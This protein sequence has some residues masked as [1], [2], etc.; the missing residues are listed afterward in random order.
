MSATNFKAVKIFMSPYTLK[1]DFPNL[2]CINQRSLSACL[3]TDKFSSFAA[4]SNLFTLLPDK[5]TDLISVYNDAIAK[6]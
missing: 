2:N 5:L 4:V 3:R 6:L 1:G